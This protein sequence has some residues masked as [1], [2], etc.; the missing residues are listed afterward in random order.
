MSVYLY[1]TLYIHVRYLLYR[2]QITYSCRYGTYWKNPSVKFTTDH[3]FIQYFSISF[4]LFQ[5]LRRS[6]VMMLRSD[7][8]VELYNRYL[9]I[10]QSTKQYIIYILV[11]GSVPFPLLLQQQSINHHPLVLIEFYVL[12]SSLQSARREASWRILRVLI[13]IT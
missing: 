6:A 2:T 8:A 7:V 1:Y 12:A 5:Q 13:Y 10:H 11:M 4:P 9:G 3:I